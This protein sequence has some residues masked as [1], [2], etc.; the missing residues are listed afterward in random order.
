M[1]TRIQGLIVVMVIVL[2]LMSTAVLAE[3]IMIDIVNVLEKKALNT[4]VEGDSHVDPGDYTIQL[5]HI[6]IGLWKRIYGYGYVNV[7]K[8]G[9]LVKA[10]F[11]KASMGMA[12]VYVK[13]TSM[14]ISFN[15]SL[16]LKIIEDYGGVVDI[17][18]HKSWYNGTGGDKPG[19]PL[20]QIVIYPKYGLALIGSSQKDIGKTNILEISILYKNNTSI[21]TV[22]GVTEKVSLNDAPTYITLMALSTDPG[23][24]IT[25]LIEH[26]NLT[27]NI[28]QNTKISSTSSSTSSIIL[29]TSTISATS[30]TY[31]RSTPEIEAMSSTINTSTPTGP[32]ETL[33]I[34][35]TIISNATITIVYPNGTTQ[36]SIVPV[37]R[38]PISGESIATI[39]ETGI[40][41]LTSKPTSSVESHVFNITFY[42]ILLVAIIVVAVAS[43]VFSR[44][45]R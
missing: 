22:N 23:L 31:T 2:I 10:A 1:N 4:I 38:K 21:L 19:S 18:L 3:N 20:T 40:N 36:T 11:S 43:L 35:S 27:Y 5:D 8:D 33:S 39:P 12:G 41:L 25:F 14:M 37:T 6:I 15:V 42:M 44:R 9:V 32:K 30:H 26:F 13:F 7:S 17:I 24:N 34:A 16:T 28:I 45:T 29:N